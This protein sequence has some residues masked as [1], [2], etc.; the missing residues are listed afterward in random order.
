MADRP[1]PLMV[2][3]ERVHSGYGG[4]EVRLG[5]A[6]VGFRRYDGTCTEEVEAEVEQTLAAMLRERLGWP[7]TYPDEDDEEGEPLWQGR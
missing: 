7:E 5:K 4:H 3:V 2:V 6:V 1:L